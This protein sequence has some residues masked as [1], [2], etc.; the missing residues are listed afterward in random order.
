[1]EDHIAAACA[2]LGVRTRVQAVAAA[3]LQGALTVLVLAQ[4]GLAEM[5]VGDAIGFDWVANLV[6]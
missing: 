3:L 5:D 4:S 6:T 1:V 2:R